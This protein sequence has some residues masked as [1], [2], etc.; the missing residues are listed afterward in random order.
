MVVLAI[1]Y[2]WQSSPGTEGGGPGHRYAPHGRRSAAGCLFV[3]TRARWRVG[4]HG[5]S[6]SACRVNGGVGPVTGAGSQSTRV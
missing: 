2:R 5:R 4:S 6:R 1:E 3:F